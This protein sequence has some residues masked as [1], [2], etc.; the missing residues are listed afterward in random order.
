[1]I[2]SHKLD[3]R[4]V[5]DPPIFEHSLK[6]RPVWKKNSLQFLHTL[7]TFNQMQLDRRSGKFQ[8]CFVESGTGDHHSTIFCQL[9]LICDFQ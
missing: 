2:Y 8:Q 4:S 3:T 7:K 9:L 6:H 5:C 1:M